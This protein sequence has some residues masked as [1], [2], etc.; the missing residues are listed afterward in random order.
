M[1]DVGPRGGALA[2]GGQW[3]APSCAIAPAAAHDGSRPGSSDW[4]ANELLSAAVSSPSA[5]PAPPPES[6]PP[7]ARKADYLRAEDIA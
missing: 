7:R 4:L 5:G 6:P 2:V 3:A 1:H